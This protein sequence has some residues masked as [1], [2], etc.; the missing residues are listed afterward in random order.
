MDTST[1]QFLHLKPSEHLGRGR[2]GGV[3]KKVQ[4]AGLP[5]QQIGLVKLN[6]YSVVFTL[7][8]YYTM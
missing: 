4:S 7:H 5:F 1:A 8:L 3:Q 2:E 6:R